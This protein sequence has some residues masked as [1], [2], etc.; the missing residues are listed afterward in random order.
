MQLLAE[1][2]LQ[3]GPLLGRH[4]VEHRLHRGHPPGHLLRAAPRRVSGFSGKK[5]PNCSMNC[6]KPGSSP[7]LVPLEHLVELGQHVLHA[8]HVGRGHVLHALGHLV[9][10]LLHRA[11]RAGWSISCSNRCWASRD[12]KS[13]ALSSRTLPARSF[14]IRSSRMLRSAAVLRAASER[15]SSPLVSASRTA[16]SI[17]WRSSSMMSSSSRAI[18]SY[19]PPRSCRS[20]RSWRSSR[21]RS[22]RSRRPSQTLAV[23]TAQAVLHHPAQRR[24][25]VAVVQQLVGE[26]IEQQIGVEVEAALRAVPPRVGEPRCHRRSTVPQCIDRPMPS[27]VRAPC[28]R[29]MHACGSLARSSSSTCRDSPTTPPRTATTPPG[30][31]SARSA[32]SF[33]RSPPS[34]AC[35]SRSGSATGA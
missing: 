23:G 21:S 17:A 3:L 22:S 7:R 34:A 15:R 30:A 12:S 19:T 16:L 2:L 31:S 18:S 6:S 8:L 10:D 4:R 33:A 35:G 26:L 1:Q 25:D 9:D 11:A 20:R 5:S 13:Y 24:V 29:L 27:S 28:N 14:G 32:P